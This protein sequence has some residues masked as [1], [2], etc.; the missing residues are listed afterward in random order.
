MRDPVHREAARGVIGKQ[1]SSGQPRSVPAN[2]CAADRQPH[3]QRADIVPGTHRDDI[4]RLIRCER[5]RRDSSKKGEATV[6]VPGRDES[7]G[8]QQRGAHA[9][10]PGVESDGAAEAEHKQTRP[11]GVPDERGL[12]AL[13]FVH[14]E[15]S[16]EG[17]GMASGGGGSEC[18]GRLLLLLLL[19]L[20]ARPRAARRTE[21]RPAT[22][23]RPSTLTPLAVTPAPAHSPL[24]AP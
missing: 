10:V 16:D 13:D 21:A 3:R 20:A 1:R 24:T 17:V 18:D 6:S 9:V 5:S 15:T 7:S 14:P 22:P 11:P 23:A 4:F 2:G 12:L 19:V 8:E